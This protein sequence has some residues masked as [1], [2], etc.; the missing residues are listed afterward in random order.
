M[1]AEQ[2]VYEL[3]LSIQK[4]VSQFGGITDSFMRELGHQLGR[5]TGQDLGSGRKSEG[6]GV[7]NS[8]DLCSGLERR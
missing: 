1:I 4:K 6:A 2:I 3:S 8:R 5:K 7:L